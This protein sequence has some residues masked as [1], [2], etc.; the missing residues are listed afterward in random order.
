[1]AQI[2]ITHT[3]TAEIATSSSNSQSSKSHKESL[4]Q[5][6]LFDS[7]FH[8]PKSFT[9][10]KQ[11]TGK[12]FRS[13]HHNW[14]Y[15]FPWLHYDQ[16]K[17]CVFCFHCMKQKNLGNLCSVKKRSPIFISNGFSVWK[18]ALE[19]FKEHESSECHKVSMTYEFIAP[20]CGDIV[21]MTNNRAKAQMAFN[22]KC[23]IVIIETLQYFGR[24]GIPIQGKTPQE[25]NFLQLLYLRCKDIAGFEDW[26]Q[27][28]KYKYTCTDVQNEIFNLLAM[29][30]VRNIVKDIKD[31]QCNTFSIIADEYT[32]TA[33][34]EQVSI[35][36]RWIDN[37]LNS[38]E[39]F[40]GYYHIPN[41]DSETIE[42]VLKDALI[43]LQLS[44]NEC[45]GQCYDGASNMLGKK[46]GVATRIQNT[47]PKAFPTHCH[48]HSLSLSV[49]DTTKESKLLSGLM[50]VS[51]EI[52]QL[53]KYSP[54][55]ENLLGVVKE[56]MEEDEAEDVNN[57]GLAKFSATRWTVRATCFRR[58]F[59]NYQ[60]LIETWK[61]CLK[62]GGLS[63]EIKARIIGCLAKM[64]TF[65]YF[66]AIL[67]GERLFAH[68]DNLSAT[69]QSKNMSAVTGQQLA[70]QTVETLKRIRSDDSFLLF[71]E[72]VL[73]KKE[74]INEV[75][76][77]TLKRK[78]NVP[79]R[80]DL[81]KAVGEHPA[82]P[83]DHY[84]K[85]YFEALDLL[86]SHIEERFNQ[87]SFQVYQRL[88]NLLIKSLSEEI[89][90]LE[91]EIKYICSLYDE[92]DIQML[93]TQLSLFRTMMG[94][95][96]LECFFD[97]LSEVQKLSNHQRT[98]IRHVITIINL[99]NVNPCSSATAE[100]TFS[101][102][103][104]NKTWLRSTMLQRRFNSITILNLHK[105]RTDNINI[106]DIAND[107]V[108]SRDV[109]HYNFGR[110]TE[111]DLKRK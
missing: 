89:E 12:Q 72:N 102:A 31:G 14:F 67:L 86:I 24:Q 27:Q 43:R 104:R 28:K 15:D 17:D 80:Y 108:A 21:E 22:R 52:V 16:Q 106:V 40:L 68:T 41:I 71:Y 79:N 19:K 61:E 35:C 47:Q 34:L 37:Q 96:Q 109:R 64:K 63:A 111:A 30:I 73:K 101:A 66:F 4:T 70:C 20:Q 38:H 13:C 82:T 51:R 25:S 65:E 99:L 26:L 94:N 6:K 105:P 39:D 103:R 84:R 29:S 53:I 78:I 81:G 56:N 90:A 110:F 83:K 10:P 60:S 88:E 42:S 75:A 1:M 8:P 2:S 55:R 59:E 3:D 98:L 36:L 5:E 23:L 77:P 48:C 50:D 91:N 58:I 74:K 76:K 69:L 44:L 95:K 62:K 107:F 93:P 97:I 100:R 9:F 32:D 54:K 87:P 92:V 7:A 57:P 18:K 33:N 49:K 11:Q 45:R 46:S 85:V